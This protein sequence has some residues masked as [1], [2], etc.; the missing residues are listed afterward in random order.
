MQR[1][2]CNIVGATT[3][4]FTTLVPFCPNWFS[5]MIQSAF[6]WLA[7]AVTRVFQLLEGFIATFAGAP[8]GSVVQS[9]AYSI[10]PQCLA[11]ALISLFSFFFDALLADGMIACRTDTCGCH[12]GIYLKPDGME[13]NYTFSNA[14]S[15][16]TYGQDGRRPQPCT[17]GSTFVDAPWWFQT[18]CNG[19]AA[20]YTLPNGVTKVSWDSR[21]RI[22][23]KGEDPP[24]SVQKNIDG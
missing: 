15:Q 8:C 22:L 5:R 2:L 23:A 4:F 16:N 17:R 3:C 12:N 14:I 9:T 6:E 11:G 19:T 20:T 7:E 21:R 24:P 1:Q 18:C 10:N 13:Q